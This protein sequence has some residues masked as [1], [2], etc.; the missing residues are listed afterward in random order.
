MAAYRINAATQ[1]EHLFTFYDQSINQSKQGLSPF[2]PTQILKRKFSGENF[3]I[4][5]FIRGSVCTLKAV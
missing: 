3:K 4:D 1:N 2:N 5:I